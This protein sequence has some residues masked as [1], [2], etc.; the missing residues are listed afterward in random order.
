MRF[1][2]L[3]LAAFLAAGPAP[4]VF[5]PGSANRHAQAYF[6]CALEAARRLGRR[7]IFL[8][9]HRAQVP[10]NLPATVLWQSWLPFHALLPHVA[11]L[12]HHG[13]IG[14]TAEALRAGIAQL[15][16]P[17]AFD[18][19]DNGA[20]VRALGAGD[21]FLKAR[22]KPGAMVNKLRRLLESQA[23]R[24]RCQALAARCR[25]DLGKDG[26]QALCMAIEAA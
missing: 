20:R 14:T 8:T 22:V 11:L 15:V 26:M 5:T 13:G 2:S 24:T 3:I 10:E 4:I 6:A 16:V 7:A 12:V 18:Q 21:S 25:E 19:F 17:L 1:R 9:S 23:V